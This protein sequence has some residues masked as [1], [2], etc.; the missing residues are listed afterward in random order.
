VD[1]LKLLQLL[2]DLLVET[3]HIVGQ[4]P[5]TLGLGLLQELV[6]VVG[7]SNV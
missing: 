3:S 2:N 5:F 6:K 1:F 4:D 7:K